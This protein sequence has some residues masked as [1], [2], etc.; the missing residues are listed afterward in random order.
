[1][2]TASSHRGGKVNIL[3]EYI[4]HIPNSSLDLA[5]NI[6]LPSHMWN[7]VKRQF[8]V[9]TVDSDIVGV[10]WK[11]PHIF[12][13]TDTDTYSYMLH[14]VLTRVA[15]CIEPDGGIFENVLH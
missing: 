6:I 4:C 13:N 3:G 2:L 1:L 14:A 7:S 15:K 8:A 5:P 11:I 10:L 9:V 12:T